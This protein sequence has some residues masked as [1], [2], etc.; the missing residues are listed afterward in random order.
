MGL[1][2][3]YNAPAA[4]KD[5]H[6][7]AFTAGMPELD[8]KVIAITGTTSGTGFIAARE[9]AKKGATCLLLNRASERA[10]KALADLK[11]AVPEGKFDPIPCDLQDFESVRQAS[12]SIKSKYQHLDVLVSAGLWSWRNEGVLTINLNQT[13]L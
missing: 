8:G 9:C 2:S 12:S 3:S 7:P 10:D 13:G 5:K 6:L 1:F 11:E 4:V